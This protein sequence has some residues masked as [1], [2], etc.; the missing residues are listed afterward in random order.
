MNPY[1]YKI[2]LRLRHPSL[3][4]AEIT[5]ALQRDPFRSWPAGE[6][7][8]T[9]RGTPLEGRNRDSYW[10][11]NAIE[12]GWP[13]KGLA[14]AIRELLDQLVPH[15]DFLDRIRSEGGNV[16]LFVGWFLEGQCG[17][18]L[19]CDLLARMADLKINL[20]LNLYPP[21]PALPPSDDTS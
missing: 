16:A 2:S 3:D 19:D 17:D 18:E 20:S 9:P 7:R 1:R 11:A 15:K 5:S 13:D 10:T 6:P 21:D 8:T 4:P 12:G 14:V